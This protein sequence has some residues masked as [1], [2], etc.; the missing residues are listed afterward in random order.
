VPIANIALLFDH[1][2]GAGE[3]RRHIAIELPSNTTESN[4]SEVMAS[5]GFSLVR[6]WLGEVVE[7]L[8]S[9]ADIWLMFPVVRIVFPR[10]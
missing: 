5:E 10:K 9:A 6:L 4:P 3:Q 2:V 1:L 7:W 8:G